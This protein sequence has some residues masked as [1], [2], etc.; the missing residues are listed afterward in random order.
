MNEKMGWD[1]YLAIGAVSGIALLI[2]QGAVWSQ[3]PPEEDWPDPLII[4]RDQCS[5]CENVSE[6]D[7]W[8]GYEKVFMGQYC[9]DCLIALGGTVGVW[10]GA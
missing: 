2:I 3:P 9:A 8:D 4:T 1:D 10:E 7:I 5:M 6:Y